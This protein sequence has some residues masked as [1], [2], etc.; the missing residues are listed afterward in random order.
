M[1]VK[2]LTGTRLLY[3]PGMLIGGKFQ[4]DCSLSRSIGYYLEALVAL[5]P[6]CKK[7]L[8]VVLRGITNDQTDPSV[9]SF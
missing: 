5:A 9:R 8:D 4:H 7:P 3:Q 1:M 2:N 6:F